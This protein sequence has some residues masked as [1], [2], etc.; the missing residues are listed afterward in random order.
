MKKATDLVVNDMTRAMDAVLTLARKIA[1]EESFT[2][3][4][5]QAAS[6][7]FEEVGAAV[8]DAANMLDRPFRGGCVSPIRFGYCRIAFGR[9]GRV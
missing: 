7:V 5:R 1:D 4:E 8:A 9:V 2:T 6:A 3:E